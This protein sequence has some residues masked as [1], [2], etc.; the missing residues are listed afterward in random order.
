MQDAQTGLCE[1]LAKA[2]FKDL[3]E[4]AATTQGDVLNVALVRGVDGVLS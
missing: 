3:V 4:K 1:L 2:G